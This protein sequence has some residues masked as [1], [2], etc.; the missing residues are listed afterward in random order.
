MILFLENRCSDDIKNST[1][2]KN[3][4]NRRTGVGADCIIIISDCDDFDF[5]MDY[6]N[7]DG[8]WET[9]CAN[10]ARCAVKMLY[11]KK[12]IKEISSF[13]SGDGICLLYTSDAADE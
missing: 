10:G 12:Y 8:T 4:C 9:F 6:Y 3:I 7:S 1:F 5:K 13:V 11:E 2:I